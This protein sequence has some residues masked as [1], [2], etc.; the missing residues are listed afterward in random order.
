M[1][2]KLKLVKKKKTLILTTFINFKNTENY[3][4][5]KQINIC[6]YI[7]IYIL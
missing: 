4:N 3:Y 2:K 1:Y 5:L 7:Y 6:E